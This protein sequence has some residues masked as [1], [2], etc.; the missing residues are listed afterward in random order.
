V[1][2][3]RLGFVQEYVIQELRLDPDYDLAQGGPLYQHQVT[4]TE[5][6][7]RD[8][9]GRVDY[10]TFKNGEPYAWSPN[11]EAW[12]VD[13]GFVPMVHVQHQKVSANNCWGLSEFHAALP[14]AREVD[15]LGS[16][17]HDQ[18]R[19]AVYPKWFITG[20]NAASAPQV[21]QTTPTQD[22]TQ[23]G[24]EE[25]AA[26]YAPMGA[27]AREL[28]FPLDIQFTTLEIKQQL[29]NLEKDYPELQMDSLRA[30]GDASAK[31]LREAR[32]KAEAKVHARR[33]AYDDGLVRATQMAIAIGG[34]R[35]Y[36]GYDGFDLD[37][38][39]DGDLE[40]RVGDRPVF[41]LDPLDT[42]EQETA[43]WNSANLA[44][45][46]GCPL[47]VF[48]ARNGWTPEQIH[49]VERGQQKEAAQLAATAP[50]PAPQAPPAPGTNVPQ[51][52]PTVEQK[53]QG[54]SA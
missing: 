53:T 35:G 10:A 46:A 24:R 14:K 2:V 38:Y 34:W 31:A 49:A 29:E 43:F 50:K 40:M 41:N 48:L 44:V 11:G 54:T 12:S 37:S 26:F 17:L 9:S 23:P 33:A 42:I 5:E 16:H 7:R 47:P 27:T 4:Y 3:D 8:P 52:K 22:A 21:K 30:A 6:C 25:I 20:V 19:K 51:E 13:Y 15:D 1:K 28:M 18:I 32:K 39:A 45:K 36:D